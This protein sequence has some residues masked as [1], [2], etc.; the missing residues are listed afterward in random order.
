MDWG[1]VQKKT[2]S[3]EEMD[4]L[5]A[6]ANLYGGKAVTC[7][8]DDQTLYEEFRKKV[9]NPMEYEKDTLRKCYIILDEFNNS[10]YS[11]D[12]HDFTSVRVDA[13]NAAKVNPTRVFTIYESV[14]MI[15]TH[16]DPIIEKKFE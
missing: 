13:F 9:E 5:L 10:Y 1:P 2:V 11:R 12:R 3:T 4:A 14:R 7:M 6:K 15:R 8:N 16:A